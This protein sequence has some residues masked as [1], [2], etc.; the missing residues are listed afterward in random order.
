M[1]L[2]HNILSTY[3]YALENYNTYI[4]AKTMS[5]PIAICNI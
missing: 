4:N 3:L 2:C 5:V 1:Y